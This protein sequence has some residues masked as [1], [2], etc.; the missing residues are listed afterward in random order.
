MGINAIYHLS[1][2]RCSFVAM[3]FRMF[4]VVMVCW[5]SPMSH[6][7]CTSRNPFCVLIELR[8]AILF[9][10]FQLHV[11]HHPQAKLGVNDT[12]PFG[13]YD[14]IQCFPLGDVPQ[15]HYY[16]KCGSSLSKMT[17]AQIV[18][19]G[20]QVMSIF[21]FWVHCC[22]ANSCCH[23]AA[24][25]ESLQWA[26]AAEFIQFVGNSV[27]SY[28]SAVKVMSPVP[29]DK[30]QRLGEATNPGPVPSYVSDCISFPDDLSFHLYF[31]CYLQVSCCYAFS[32]NEL[33]ERGIRYRQSPDPVSSKYN[34][35]DSSKWAK[36]VEFNLFVGNKDLNHAT[37]VTN[38]PPVPW[39]K[40][41]RLGEATNPGPVEDYICDD[42]CF[43]ESV[44]QM[45]I[46]NP[47]G[48]HSNADAVASLG[49][50]VWAIAETHS[51][52]KS[53]LGLRREFRSLG[54]NC[55]FCDPVP[56]VS[57]SRND[58]FRGI[59]SGVACVSSYPMRGLHTDH[60]SFI[61][62]S[63]R[64][65]VS[66]ISLGPHC[67]L[68]VI[69]IYAPP[70]NNKTIHDPN[71]LT[72]EIID[73]AC[74]IIDDWHG[75][76]IL[77]GDFNQNVEFYTSIQKLIQKGWHNAQD[78]SV[79]KH[80]HPKKPTC[81][82]SQ[83]TSCNSQIFCSPVIA[84][85]MVYCNSLDD[86]LFP[87]H[88]TLAMFCDLPQFA[89]PKIH[90]CI[91]DPFQCET[92]DSE[93]M[94]QLEASCV[95]YK[96]QFQKAI[97]NQD[98]HE[99]SRLWIS[100]AE[101]VLAHGARN[102]NGQ[103]INFSHKNF[104]RTKGPELK[105]KPCATPIN[106]IARPGETKSINSQA[107]TWLRQHLRQSRRLYTLSHLLL[108]RDKNPTEANTKA[109]DELWVAITKA[110]G[111]RAGFPH[112]AVN[113]LQWT[114]PYKTP[115]AAAGQFFAKS[116]REYFTQ[117]D[118][119]FKKT[120]QS[121]KDEVLKNDWAKGGGLTFA[122]IREAPPRSLCY[123]AKSLKFRIKRVPWKKQGKTTIL[124]HDTEGMIVNHPIVFQGQTAVVVDIT[125][126]SVTVNKPLFLRNGVD[127]VMTQKLHIYDSQKA[128]QEVVTTWN[129]FMQRDRDQLT[130]GWTQ[131]EELASQIPQQD[132]IEIPQFDYDLW[133]KVQSTTPLKSARGSCG[134]TVKEMR[135]LPR[136]C[137]EALFEIFKCIELTGVWPK[138]WLYAFT[139]M[140]PKTSTP[141]S[142]LD[143]RPITILSR[144]YRQWSRYKAVALLVGMSHRIPNLIAGGTKNMSSLLLSAYFQE[145]LESEPSDTRC[146]GITIDIIKCYNII[147]RYPLSLF[148]RKLGWPA[149]L[150]TTYISALMNME[151]SFQ[152]L[153]T[154]SSWQ[155]S[156][157]GVPEGCALAVA[158]MLTLSASLYYYLKNYVP[159]CEL[160][161]F[162]DNWA[163]K[164][165]TVAEN[166]IGIQ[167]L[168][169]FCSSL[170]LQISVPKSWMWALNKSTI[171]QIIIVTNLC[172]VFK[173][174]L[175]L[176]QRTWALM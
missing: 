97:E 111:F 149:S 67:V 74:S 19:L 60:P 12:L 61:S 167:T 2:L 134:F 35:F 141:E 57:H 1:F 85:S 150:V 122:S 162:A 78:L 29:W 102:E 169:H 96:N 79:Q 98:V 47:T 128:T 34:D 43:P 157:T 146:N 151:R 114:Y 45:G 4:L 49:K 116:F 93:A 100:K 155:R 159:Q 104:G 105:H 81:I 24:S 103:P 37:A 14:N 46:I 76:A 15:Y 5:H 59:A 99:A 130:E 95:D 23:S 63:C 65:L 54:F 86:H 30:I 117:I 135:C 170:R 3:W 101:K 6:R 164:F 142:P 154:V 140:L 139:V 147:P 118:Q 48:L 7:M 173:Y 175:F 89:R 21:L 9:V 119:S 110:S 124:C 69:T 92:F 171:D 22:G 70:P 127:Y 108:A 77:A 88:P 144:I 58:T 50:G 91:P 156:Y 25:D 17:F 53:Q 80:G 31:H 51:T 143:L 18:A 44:F 42:I 73:Y 13:C 172:R 20:H 56:P 160:I 87:G 165:M 82:T 123:V 136:W 133:I 52:Y 38:V 39:D 71:A 28:A 113:N 131:A 145:T 166:T 115:D 10:P 109:C 72:T 126:G 33:L 90:W 32:P 16:G 176:T 36:A 137:I 106:R 129:S 120:K 138:A 112:W 8:D 174:Q 163:L 11:E 27:S 55:E 75:P 26:R 168:E 84:Q 125:P 107:P 83:G 66:H 152:V 121:Q 68:L 148:M 94:N 161:T 158:A 62:D 41:H 40:I 153:D 132:E 64:F